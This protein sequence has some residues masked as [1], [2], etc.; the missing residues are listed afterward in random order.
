ML[1]TSVARMGKNAGKRED[2]VWENFTSD[3]TGRK[4][5]KSEYAPHP[6]LGFIKIKQ[7]I[8]GARY[9][10]TWA[11]EEEQKTLIACRNLLCLCLICMQ[12]NV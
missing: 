2:A 11:S 12:N 6:S 9:I 4:K 5:V 1:F 3:T 7:R 8:F 10:F